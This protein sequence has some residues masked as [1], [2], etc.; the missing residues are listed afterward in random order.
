[1]T[2]LK[3]LPINLS[4]TWKK[5][6]ASYLSRFIPGERALGIHCIGA[7]MGPTTGLDMLPL[8]GFETSIIQPVA[9]SLQYAI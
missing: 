4:T 1:M 5:W 3:I 9:Q 8:P 7:W 2:H 6:F